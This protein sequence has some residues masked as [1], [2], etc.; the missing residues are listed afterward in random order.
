MTSRQVL[1]LHTTLFIVFMITMGS[2]PFLAM[3]YPQFFSSAFFLPTV[4]LGMALT[5]AS[6][7]LYG[8]CPFTVWENQAR[9]KEGKEIY[10]GSC[11]PHYARLWF[12]LEI[13]TAI[14][15]AILVAFLLLP[16]GVGIYEKYL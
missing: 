12:G 8:G 7:K 6:W 11:L 4:V 3:I 16:I 1:A 2:T 5:L 13:P 15:N 9:T 14:F 10:L